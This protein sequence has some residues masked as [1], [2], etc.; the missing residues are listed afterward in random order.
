[1]YYASI[2][3]I[4]TALSYSQS[5]LFILGFVISTALTLIPSPL[6]EFRYFVIPYLLW[7]LHLS[8]LLVETTKWGG[9]LEFVWYQVINMTVLTIFVSRPFIWESEPGKTQ[10][11]IW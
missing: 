5:T 9:V 2:W 4:L 1:M 7:R 11:F 8:P 3:I 6:L 10:R